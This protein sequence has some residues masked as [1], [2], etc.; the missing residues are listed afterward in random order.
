MVIIG[1]MRAFELRGVGLDNLAAVERPPPRPGPGQ[2]LVR[3]RA[4]S[5]NFR[6]VVIAEGKYRF[7]A[8]KLPLIP[9]SDAAG[10]V[11]GVGQ[12]V[13]R[14]KPGDRVAGAFFQR[15]IDG[16]LNAEKAASALGGAID[17]VLAEQIVLEQDAAVKFPATLSFEEAATL[18][19]A[20]VTA[21][22]G[23]MAHGQL[24]AGE[25]VLTMGTGGVSLFALQFAKMAGAKVI[26]TSSSDS[27]LEQ[28]RALG[29]DE[30]IN[31]KSM[32]EWDV[33]A[34]ELNGGRGV[35]HVVEVGG[36]TTLPR[37]LRAVESGGH[38][39]LV[40]T[41]S[42]VPDLKENL[43]DKAVRLDLVYVGNVRQFEAMNEAIS[44]SG[45]HP[46]VDRVFRFEE[47][48]QAYQYL[49]DGK[50]FGKIVIAL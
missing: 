29:A 38:I 31:Y 19:C 39:A 7:Q 8:K 22:V 16:P 1:P 12:G 15:W 13:H 41:L 45:L 20:G 34:R 47:T 49:K 46:V 36:G 11:I 33:R 5:L 30:V 2:V 32:P 10:E 25:T 28:G 44:T 42:G 4:A 21:W 27:K 6:D 23:L 48:R 37:S 35:D 26:L 14:L 18:P 50:H 3:V 9:L 43:G 40:G 17:G 24:E